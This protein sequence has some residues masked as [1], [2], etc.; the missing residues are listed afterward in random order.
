[1]SASPARANYGLGLWRCNGKPPL[2]NTPSMPTVNL[3]QGHAQG[4]YVPG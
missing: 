4:G 1:M 2:V 3:L